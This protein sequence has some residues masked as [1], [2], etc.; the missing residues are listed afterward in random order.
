M[1]RLKIRLENG[2][3]NYSPNILQGEGIKVYK[4]DKGCKVNFE[5]CLKCILKNVGATIMGVK[6]SELR[7]IKVHNGDINVWEDCKKSITSYAEMEIVELNEDWFR[8]KV[9][10]YHK[11]AL[12][13]ELRELE[14]LN[15]LKEIGYPQNYSLGLYVHV[16]VT[17]LRSYEL[18]KGEF[19]H[20][21]GLFFGYPLKDVL[22]F[23]GYS[24]L[25]FTCCEEW[26]IYG[27][28]SPS[29]MRKSSFDKARNY[30]SKRLDSVV[31]INHFYEVV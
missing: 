23:M 28:K 10:I 16:L 17:K 20:E 3:T 11:S 13:K 12:D 26:R 21:I 25:E 1:A 27:D 14:N 30:F 31:N 24:D 2:P 6:P 29:L 8:K 18:G 5:E 4:K 15:F 19:P 9:F 22:G 7:S